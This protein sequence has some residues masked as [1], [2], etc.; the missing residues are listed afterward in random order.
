MK[1]LKLFLIS[2]SCS[3]LLFGGIEVFAAN[4]PMCEQ[5]GN[6]TQL[7]STGNHLWD[8]TSQHMVRYS[9]NGVLK[10]MSC[11]N[12]IS[13]DEISWICTNGHGVVS[14]R[15]HHTENHSSGRCNNLDYYLN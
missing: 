10:Q 11:T 9:E 1:K 4:C 15:I 12:T 6:N 7:Y 5:Y 3:I 14:R 2:I 13:E 8:S